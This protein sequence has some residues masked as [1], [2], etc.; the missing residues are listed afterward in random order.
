MYF[1]LHDAGGPTQEFEGEVYKQEAETGTRNPRM[2]NFSLKCQVIRVPFLRLFMSKVLLH[3][4]L[5]AFSLT[6]TQSQKF[7][8]VRLSLPVWKQL[9]P[10][11]VKIHFI[12]SQS[13]IFR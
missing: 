4:S 6:L 10:W 1:A 12:K 8:L 7:R 5:C 13:H 11:D 3:S 9:G 2:V